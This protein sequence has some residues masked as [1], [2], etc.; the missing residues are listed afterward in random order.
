MQNENVLFNTPVVLVS[1]NTV[2]KYYVSAYATLQDHYDPFRVL[3]VCAHAQH[4][5]KGEVFR[6]A[7]EFDILA[8]EILR[9]LAVKG[10]GVKENDN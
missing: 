6:Y 9:R 3:K 4:T 10:G 5:H 2:K 7:S 8:Y 1:G